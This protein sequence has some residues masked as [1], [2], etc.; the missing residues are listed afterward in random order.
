[1][2]CKITIDTCN[3][4]K[5][6]LGKQGSGWGYLSWEDGTVTIE[7]SFRTNSPQIVDLIQA[8]SVQT[9]YRAE[10]M[11]VK[12]DGYGK[13]EGKSFNNWVVT[14]LEPLGEAN[15]PKKFDA[16]ELIAEAKARHEA[17]EIEEDEM[18]RF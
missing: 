18:S 10:A 5:F 17:T 11:L 9:E 6:T 8:N 16:Q 3:V 4:F 1:M 2:S 14:K 12:T 7:Q 13:N 15:K